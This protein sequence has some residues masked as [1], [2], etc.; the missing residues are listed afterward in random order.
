VEPFFAPGGGIFLFVTGRS[1]VSL[2]AIAAGHYEAGSGSFGPNVNIELPLIETVP[3]APAASITELGLALGASR[4]EGG[5]EVASVTAPATCP[6]GSFRWRINARF[7]DE[8]K[9]LPETSASAEAFSPCLPSGPPTTP[10]PSP[11]PTPVTSAPSNASQ[12]PAAPVFGHTAVVQPVSGVVLIELPGSHIFIP[13]DSAANVPFGTIIDASRG[14]VQLIS[15]ADTSGRTQTGQ[16]YGGAFRL[17]QTSARSPFR[18][19]RSVGITIL[20]LVGRLPTGCAA[21]HARAGMATR[22]KARGLW[23]DAHGNFR[24]AGR[25]ASA[26]VRGTKWLTEDTCAGTLVKVARGVVSVDD[27][28]THRTVLVKAGRSFLSRP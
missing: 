1:P 9:P 2:E 20:S 27:F 13:L 7:S 14:T 21:K 28:R 23:G 6:E 15:A 26:T 11:A 25:Y 4:Q 18:G 8:G 16:F 24:T 22:H 17:G 19:G 12:A 3:G 5:S 10:A